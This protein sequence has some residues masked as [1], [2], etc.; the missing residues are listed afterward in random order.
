MLLTLS[1]SAHAF[2][3][4]LSALKGFLL[5]R[6]NNTESWLYEFKLSKKFRKEME[7]TYDYP[8]SYSQSMVNQFKEA[9]S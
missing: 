3:I 8:E 9:L 6:H 4:T 2:I 7:S 5:D 1:K